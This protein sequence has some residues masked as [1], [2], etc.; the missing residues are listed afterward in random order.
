MTYLCMS[1]DHRALDGAQAAQFLVRACA[2]T[3]EAWEWLSLP[4]SRSF[5]RPLLLRA[6]RSSCSRTARRRTTL[7][8]LEHPPVYTTRQA[9]RAR[10]TCRWARTGT[11]RRASRCATPTAA[12]RVTY[13]GPGPAGRLPDHGGRAGRRLTCTRWSG[14]IVAALADEGIAAEAARRALHRRLGGRL[15]R[16][17]R[18]ACTCPRGVTTHGLRRERGQRP[19]AVRVDR[20]VRDRPRARD[21]GVARRRARALAALLPQADGLAL[22]R[23]VRAAPADRVRAAGCSSAARR[24]GMSTAL[25]R[26]PGRR[27]GCSSMGEVRPFRERKP[28]VVQGAGAGR[29][30]L[31]RAA[32]DD[33]GPGAAHGLPGGG[34]PEHRRVLG[35]RHRHL[36]DP[37]RHLHAP[38]RLLQREDGQADLQ[39][40]ARA[41]ARGAVGEADGPAPRGDHERGPRRPARPRRERL[42]RRD[43]LDPAHG[44]GLQGRGAHARTSAAR[45]CRSR[46]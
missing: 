12:A 46:A 26:E 38:L 20:A 4:R 40:P 7:L 25:A 14:A 11:A 15:A 35:A 45:R 9:H 2:G 8:L 10:A 39:R 19:S 13:H 43:P 22:R 37:R 17:A 6:W 34:L 21:L 27:A 36:H 42:R 28:A 5:G 32:R 33:R 24:G 29:P 31:P 18:S 23:G 16:S 44:A 30:A 3:L 1:W 41:A